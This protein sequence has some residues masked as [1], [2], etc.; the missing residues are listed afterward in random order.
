[1]EEASK[2]MGEFIQKSEQLAQPFIL[3][4]IAT[5]CESKEETPKTHNFKFENN[6]EAAKYNTKLIKH[7]DY[8]FEKCLN[9]QKGSML[10][11]GSEF[12]N[13]QKI[14]K[15]LQ[16]HEDWPEIRDIISI[17]CDYQLQPETDEETRL[18]DLQAM[19]AR[20][21]H[22]SA[23]KHDATLV[24]AFTKEIQKGWL[25]PITVES[26]TKVKHL[27]IIPL[28]VAE[29][30]SI[31]ENGERITKRRVTHD[32]SF[33]A[34]SGISVNNKVIEALLQD[35]IYGQCLRR[36]LH[37]LQAMRS[38]HP[39][40]RIYMTKYDMDAA[41]RRLHSI[42]KHALKCVTVIEKIAYIPLRLPFGVSPGPSLYSTISEAIYDVVNDLLNERKWDREKLNSP[43]VSL[44]EKPEPPDLSID[45]EPVRKLS[46]YIPDRQSFAD[47]YI[48]DCLSVA[49]D[50]GDEV[51]RSQEAPPLVVHSI[52]RPLD[53]SDPLPRDDNIS[54]KKLKGEG[55]PSE[56]KVM[57]GWLIDTVTM[58]VYLPPDKAIDW[59]SD[60]KSILERNTVTSKELEKTIG[61]LNHTGYIMPVGRYFLNRLRHLLQRCEKYG[62]QQLQRWEKDD[63][64]LWQEFL[65]NA[66]QK[67][68]ST[69][70][71][72]HTEITSYI[73]T[74]ACEHGIGGYNLMTGRAWR[75]K[76]PKW[77]TTSCHINLLEFIASFIGIWLE[78]IN[79][80]ETKYKKFRALTDNSSAVG[81]L[82]KS[83]FN[84]KTHPGHDTVARTLA[85]V[86]MNSESSVE[87]QHIRGSHNVVADSLSRD[88]H[89]EKTH[90]EFILKTL[91]PSQAR[92]GFR[93]CETLPK[94]ITLWL[95]SLKGI[96]TT[97]EVLPPRPGKSK[98]GILY[99]GRSSWK[100][101][102]SM[103]NSLTRTKK[104]KKSQLCKHSQ[105]VLDEM[106]M[107]AE[108]KDNL[109]VTPFPPPSIT[110][111]RP[112]GR[113]FGGT[114]L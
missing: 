84:P 82:Y 21:N 17:G 39:N 112:F 67:G 58:R 40:T 43:Q 78:I 29:Q 44:L 89:M 47:G 28:G 41:Y 54:L 51:Q 48:D 5:L 104:E 32:A 8:D 77:M 46:V 86:L 79:E 11:A 30:F 1:M 36:I 62:K 53:T 33:P 92:N 19:I 14:R 64:L 25:L 34:P 56:K 75:F 74:D 20:G 108:T 91:F 101:V 85:K 60:I 2:T 27:S 9:K 109:K 102:I 111:V 72:T 90:L 22:K 45:P 15:L 24:K 107:V 96:L 98:V 6:R 114:R 16:Y 35:C 7:T 10:S 59:T 73:I 65:R 113:T 80:K 99:D 69:N 61:R 94:E 50:I 87:S 18:S 38:K 13:I 103:T 55:Q 105:Q 52:F 23:K 3:H 100:S 37:G 83:N 68:V 88:H 70:N 71:I 66:S 95:D 81:W 97:S 31:D 4:Q 93:I 110:Y 26:L 57:L 63:L 76:L 49:L 12:R 42:P 106:R